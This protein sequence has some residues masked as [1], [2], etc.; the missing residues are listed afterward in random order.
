MS[1]VSD[2]FQWNDLIETKSH[3]KNLVA[4]KFK[5]RIKLHHVNIIT[6]EWFTVGIKKCTLYSREILNSFHRAMGSW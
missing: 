5:K 1:H 3:E 4:Y 6:M 2:G